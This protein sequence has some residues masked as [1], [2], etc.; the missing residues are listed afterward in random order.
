MRNLRY[1][2][3][4]ASLAFL[5]ACEGNYKIEDPAKDA[6]FS[7]PPTELIF[8]YRDAPEALPAVT[9]NGHDVSEFFSKGDTQAVALGDDLLP[10][11]VEGTNRFQVDPPV[12]P[13]SRFIYDTK[14][15]EVVIVETTG[16]TVSGFTIDSV[17]TTSLSLNGQPVELNEDGS[18]AT[19]FAPTN[20]L[21]F[22]AEDALGHTSSVQFRD[23]SLLIDSAVQA[24]INQSGLDFAAAE[25]K[26]I[27]NGL[28]FNAL[29][30]G[31]EV[32][33]DVRNG[34]LGT[35]RGREGR[36]T[37][38]ALDVHS[39]SFDPTSQGLRI[40]GQFRNI[41]VR[42]RLVSYLGIL[43]DIVLKPTAF[44]PIANLDGLI[45]LDVENGKPKL[46]IRDFSVDLAFLRFTGALG[47]FDAILNNV[48][49]NTITLLDRRITGRLK[50]PIG[51]AVNDALEDLIPSSYA[52]D[53]NGVG[54]DVFFDLDSLSTSNDAILVGVTGGLE[55]QDA[56]ALIPNQF[57]PR[58]L[59]GAVSGPLPNIGDL[60]VALNV[61]VIN[62]ALA[63]AFESGITHLT[64]QDGDIQLN[65]PRNDAL[66]SNGDTRVLINP[67][68][69]PFVN[70]SEVNGNPNMALS[71]IGLDVNV[72][73]KNNDVWEPTFS[74]Q[75]S[76]NV[77][78]GVAIGDDNNLNVA[79]NSAPAIT[80][81]NISIGENI[82]LD[83]VF[84]E[85]TVADLMPQVLAIFSDVLQGIRIPALAG[86]TITLDDIDTLGAN[87]SHLSLSGSLGRE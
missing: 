35:R 34:P 20:I 52:F 3:L 58:Y 62:H 39:L 44:A 26:Q 87:N 40:R 22:S 21:E 32:Y 76:A 31:T 29:V 24:R 36:I 67:V 14:G 30:A 78:L 9:L 50:G 49:S 16:S 33:S 25:A 1:I 54:V 77:A 7:T 28:D 71:V 19:D 12:G 41:A 60:G 8:S 10:F 42:F 53:V 18:F 27:I 11:I 51:N 85:G 59:P 47:V 81:H 82:T 45:A 69:A 86:Y 79:V 68:T 57:G 64:I 56:S 5:A 6:V 4:V 74:T 48:I 13:K 38:M 43:P 83:E 23:D 75:V 72:Q 63:K 46:D 55:A 17:A 61:N 66:G 70:L 80:F 2:I 37:G 73:T 65:L 84:I 15:P